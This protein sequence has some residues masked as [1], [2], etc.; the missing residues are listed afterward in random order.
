[1]T[2]FCQE[3][4]T[5]GVL[6]LCFLCLFGLMIE[7]PQKMCKLQVPHKDLCN[8]PTPMPFFTMRY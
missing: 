8:Q 1:M 5:L 2:K 4:E 6:F 3:T 7:A